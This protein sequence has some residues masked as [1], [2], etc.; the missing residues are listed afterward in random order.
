MTEILI[1]IVT[2][3]LIAVLLA[4]ILYLTSKKFVVDSDA[5]IT[6]IMEILPKANCGGCGYPGCASFAEVCVKA[7]GLKGKFCPV[8]G[9]VVMEKMAAILGFRVSETQPTVAVVRCQGDCKSRPRINHYDGARNCAI[10]ASLYEGETACSWG[11][12]GGGDCVSACKFGAIRMNKDTLLPEIDEDLCTS[13]GA[14]TQACPRGLIEI[15]V[16]GARS[17]RIYV[18]CNNKDKGSVARKECAVACIGCGKCVKIC[19]FEAIS[20]QDNLAYIDAA[21]CRLCR[22]CVSECPQNSILELNFP[23]KRKL[24][25]ELEQ[26]I[27]TENKKL[28]L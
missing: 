1:A 17:R 23:S 5:R 24:E 15:R 13:C 20:L 11:C 22:K 16:R 26:I 4:V 25:G 9:Q 8:G 2:L 27:G 3:G 12:L 19:P 7:E 6:Q 10:M 14:C 18:G 21:K 28:I